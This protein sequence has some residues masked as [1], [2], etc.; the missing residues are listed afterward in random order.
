MINRSLVTAQEL[1]D[2]L[3]NELR[4]QEACQLCEIK[5]INPLQLPDQDGCNWSESVTLNNG[6]VPTAIVSPH[7][8]R[9]ILEARR[10]FNLG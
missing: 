8:H 5:G 9:I 4:K 1:T 10:K 2:W 3:T 7:A 6:G